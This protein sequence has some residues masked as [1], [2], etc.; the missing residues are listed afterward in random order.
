MI[1]FVLGRTGSGKST[2]ARFLAEAA[3]SRGWSVQSF[4]D[5]Y[6]LRDMYLADTIQRFRP[7]ENDGFEVLDLSIY[8]I[9][10][11][12]L[13]RQVRSHYNE[14]KQT[15]ITVEFTSNNYLHTLQF[16]GSDLLRDAHVFFVS[17]DLITCLERTSNRIFHQTT[18]DD[19]Y[20]KDTVLLS[21][22]PC[23]YMPPWIGENKVQYVHN[24]E[25]LDDLRNRI[26]AL[27]P[28]LLEQKVQE[29]TGAYG[30]KPATSIAE[31]L[32][33]LWSCVELAWRYISLHR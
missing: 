23:P 24:M 10:I 9:A 13:A 6:F 14:N 31:T 5:Y 19:Y 27:T 3:R 25:S 28:T 8:E 2:T 11:R 18:R 30:E 17:A 26:L 32:S 20:V 7:T 1:V 22:Y 4:N 12:L 33:I 16:F 29:H 15:L 21:H